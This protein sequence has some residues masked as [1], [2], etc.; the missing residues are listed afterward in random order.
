MWILF[1]KSCFPCLHV[2]DG[3]LWKTSKNFC[4]PLGPCRLSFLL[5]HLWLP[6]S[7]FSYVI[8]GGNYHFPFHING[9]PTHNHLV[10]KRTLNH[11]G[12]LLPNVWVLVSKIS[13][14]GFDSHGSRYAWYYAWYYACAQYLWKKVLW[15]SQVSHNSFCENPMTR[16]KENTRDQYSTCLYIKNAEAL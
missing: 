4:F 9:N 10:H 15:H 6:H 8:L 3:F 14:C 1:L 2:L 13:G 12:L 7:L 16:V 5:D 11:L